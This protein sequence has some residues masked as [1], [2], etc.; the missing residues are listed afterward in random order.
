MSELNLTLP[1]Y[2]L[3][4]AAKELQREAIELLILAH[5]GDITFYQYPDPTCGL[6]EWDSVS[7]VDIGLVIIKHKKTGRFYQQFMD[8]V[9]TQEQDLVLP[10]E[11]M[12]KT[13]KIFNPISA[14]DTVG[15][16]APKVHTT[17]KQCRFIVELLKSHGLDDNDFKGSIEELRRKIANKIPN[18]GDPNVDDNTLVDWLKKAGVR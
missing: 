8:E 11:E 7:C 10:L 1:Y 15:R 14:G 17:A 18:I 3:A 13:Y 6:L 12:I 9:D 5:A 2:P 4:L 16:I